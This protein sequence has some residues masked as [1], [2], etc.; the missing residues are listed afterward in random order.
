[1]FGDEDDD[2][3]D[4]NFDDDNFVDADDY[5]V[6]VCVDFNYVKFFYLIPGYNF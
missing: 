4:V 1:M 2:L 5:N 3:N 6:L